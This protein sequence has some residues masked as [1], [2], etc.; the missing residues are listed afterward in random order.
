MC[1]SETRDMLVLGK[2]FSQEDKE[3]DEIMGNSSCL[4]GKKKKIILESFNK[5]GI[6]LYLKI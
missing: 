2:S 3:C 5:M 1:L 6:I 4:I